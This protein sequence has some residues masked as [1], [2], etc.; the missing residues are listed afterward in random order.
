MEERFANPDLM[1]IDNSYIAITN[2]P[3]F[4][5]ADLNVLKQMA[6][7]PT[8]DDTSTYATFEGNDG[9]FYAEGDLSRVSAHNLPE[10]LVL[11]L[12]DQSG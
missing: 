10:W 9:C 8:E 12:I 5:D 11:V 2:A 3:N 7:M 4:N 6:V 1:S